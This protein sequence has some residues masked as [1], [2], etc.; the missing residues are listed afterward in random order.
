MSFYVRQSELCKLAGRTKGNVNIARVDGRIPSEIRE[1]GTRV[2][3]IDNPVIQRFIADHP[4][5]ITAQKAEAA[6]NYVREFEKRRNRGDVVCEMTGEADMMS[7]FDSG[8]GISPMV[9]SAS[10]EELDRLKKEK[11]VEKLDRTVSKMDVQMKA[12]TGDLIERDYAAAWIR[13]YIGTIHQGH[14]NMAGDGLCGDLYNLA[15]KHG[16][17]AREA[18]KAMEKLLAERLSGLLKDSMDAMAK[19]PL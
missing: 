14:L 11:E 13:R 16:S 10:E 19:N 18:E 9:K 8:A 1:D 2:Y 12:L 17:D 5:T 7:A 3:D 4:K 15:M 6:K